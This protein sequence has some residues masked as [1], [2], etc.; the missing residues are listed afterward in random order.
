MDE[1]MQLVNALN[2]VAQ[3]ID[4]LSVRT[5][6]KVV[7]RFTPIDEPPKETTDKPKE[8]TLS[9]VRTVLAEKSRA[10]F[11]AEVKELLNKHGAEKLSDIDPGEYET[12]MKEA[13]ALGS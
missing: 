13:E 1:M 5:S 12:L 10:G 6:D 11:K 9:D 3:A 8:L 2:S 7:E 4:K